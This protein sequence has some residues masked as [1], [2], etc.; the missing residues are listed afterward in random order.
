M[1]VE[2]DANQRLHRTVNQP[3]RACW[4]RAGEAKRYTA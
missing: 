1:I 3:H 2:N 4:F